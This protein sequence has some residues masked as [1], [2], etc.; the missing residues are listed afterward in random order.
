M[1]TF[2]TVLP[3]VC[4]VLLCAWLHQKEYQP[5]VH[6]RSKLTSMSLMQSSWKRLTSTYCLLVLQRRCWQSSVIDVYMLSPGSSAEVLAI[7]CDWCLHAVSW[8]FS[9]GA[10]NRLWLMSTCCPLILQRRCWQ[11]SVIDVYMPSPG[12]SAEALA[13]VCD[14]SHIVVYC[15][16]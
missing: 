8:F 7:V 16:L 2:R 11:L 3:L 10:G 4:I 9:G 5:S 13:I 15:L 6:P 12:S 1:P 14:W